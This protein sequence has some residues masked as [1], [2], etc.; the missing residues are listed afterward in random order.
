MKDELNLGALEKEFQGD[1]SDCYDFCRLRDH[2]IHQLFRHDD[3]FANLLAFD[4][5]M[6]YLKQ[7]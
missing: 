6:E 1:P 5:A 2:Q 4:K 7:L 3:D